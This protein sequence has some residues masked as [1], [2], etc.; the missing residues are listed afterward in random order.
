MR[1][2]REGITGLGVRH[3][4]LDRITV[5]PEVCNG[6]PCMRG[7]R[8]PVSRLLGLLASSERPET[9]LKDYPYLEEEDINQALECAVN[10][11]RR[12]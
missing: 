6:K 2:R 5:N 12:P 7:L 1:R 9:I 3:M 8:F 10:D 11:W 4:T